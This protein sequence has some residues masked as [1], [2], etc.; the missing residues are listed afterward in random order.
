MKP[1]RR[2][3]LKNSAAAGLAS[4]LAGGMATPIIEASGDQTVLQQPSASPQPAPTGKSD[5]ETIRIAVVQQAANPGRVEENRN[6]ALRYAGAALAK[7]AD[8]VLFHEEMLIG[9]VENMRELAEPLG[10]PTMRAFQSLLKGSKALVLCGLQERSGDRYYIAA[11]LIGSGGVVANYHKTHLFWKADGPRHEPSIYT[12]GDRLM[13][14]DV[15]GHKSGVM[16]CYD[17][18]FPEMARSYANLNCRILFWMNNRTSR[19]H[20]EVAGLAA[21]NSIIMATSCCCGVDETGRKC[22]GG[23]NITDA[24]GKLLAEIWDKEG[25]IYANVQPAE[26]MRIR[27]ENCLYRGQRGDLY[28]YPGKEAQRGG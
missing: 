13:T 12:P 4:A 6:K 10:G 2:D 3:F 26:A 28:F 20:Q 7:G 5:K 16:I 23:S 24:H 1:T 25:V 19:G 27:K 18:D 11:T 8:V 17:G 14:F 9:C 21:A 22:S 15:R